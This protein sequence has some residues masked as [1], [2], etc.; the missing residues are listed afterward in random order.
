VSDKR[1]AASLSIPPRTEAEVYAQFAQIIEER[2]DFLALMF[3]IPH[4]NAGIARDYINRAVSLMV[5]GT[6]D[7]EELGDANAILQDPAQTLHWRMAGLVIEGG[8]TLSRLAL[9]NRQMD[10]YGTGPMPGP[11]DVLA[12]TAGEGDTGRAAQPVSAG[13]RCRPRRIRPEEKAPAI[14]VALLQSGDKADE[15]FAMENYRSAPA[16]VRARRW[17]TR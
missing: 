12:R 9:S 15:D 10:L 2:G 17:M 7:I 16:E 5:C 13:G 6:K 4:V 8:H 1:A 11:A 14:L 3:A